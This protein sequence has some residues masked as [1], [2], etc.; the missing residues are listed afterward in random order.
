MNIAL[1]KKIEELPAEKLQLLLK[2]L[3]PAS[4]SQK[5]LFQLENDLKSLNNTIC[6]TISTEGKLDINALLKSFNLLK[7]RHETLR[8]T[9]IQINGE[10][11]Q[12]ISPKETEPDIELI[13]HSDLTQSEKEE[14]TGKLITTE[15]EKKF[16]LSKNPPWNIKIIKQAEDLHFL[17][18]T[19]HQIIFDGLSTNILLEEIYALYLNETQKANISLPPLELQYKD[20]SIYERNF[21][22]E[23]LTK[24][25]TDFWK[26]YLD[27]PPQNP[28]FP[29]IKPRTEKVLYRAEQ[30]FFNLDTGKTTKIKELS[31]KTNLS[32]FMI[33]LAV[34]SETV[35]SY[36]TQNDLIIS[37]P[38]AGR[39]LQGSEKLIGSFVNMIPVR[40]RKS[41][42]TD[43]SEFLNV[44]KNEVL[45]AQEHQNFPFRR[46]LEALYPNKQ[47]SNYGEAG[48]EPLFRIACDYKATEQKKASSGEKGNL[49]IRIIDSETKFT[50]CDLF[51][52]FWEEENCFQGSILYNSEL[53]SPQTVNTISNQ[54]VE[55]LTK[56]TN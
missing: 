6:L 30:L 37:I 45:T 15:S 2:R 20:Y 44:V 10:I 19:F 32:F 41:E 36:T 54:L 29:Q 1:L 53:L 38:V 11:K 8:T 39:N 14:K 28:R 4:E 42:S 9:L 50:G 26:K 43:Q 21:L 35:Y 3:P 25:E 23:D 52:K 24:K 48:E 49:D 18:L 33:G 40:I 17:L 34:L 22:T 47:L 16:D 55:N 56:L 7:S 46:I 51:V 13:D 31:R 27:N 12:I 5:R